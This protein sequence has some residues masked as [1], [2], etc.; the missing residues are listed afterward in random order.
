MSKISFQN[1]LSSGPENR[2]NCKFIT[3]EYE[4]SNNIFSINHYKNII[5][6]QLSLGYFYNGYLPIEL[7]NQG[8]ILKIDLIFI[9]NNFYINYLNY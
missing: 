3:I 6:E 8:N 9:D 4:N 7:D 1:L 5:E 2:P